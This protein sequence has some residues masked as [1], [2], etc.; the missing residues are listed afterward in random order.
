MNSMKVGTLWT[1]MILLCLSQISHKVLDQEMLLNLPRD[2]RIDLNYPNSR[3]SSFITMNNKSSLLMGKL[4]EIMKMMMIS[5]LYDEI[6]NKV[7]I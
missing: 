7:D 6:N 2:T 4:K 3:I 5:E 1:L